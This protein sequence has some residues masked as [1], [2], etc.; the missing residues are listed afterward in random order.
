[1]IFPNSDT[2]LTAATSVA[3][4]FVNMI[5]IILETVIAIEAIVVVVAVVVIATLAAILGMVSSLS[6]VW[7]RKHIERARLFLYERNA[8]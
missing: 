1:M 7:I 8:V 4:R 5:S 6:A 3:T 2:M